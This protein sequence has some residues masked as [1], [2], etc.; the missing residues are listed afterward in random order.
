MAIGLWRFSIRNGI[1]AN[2]DDSSCFNAVMK[3]RRDA[4]VRL[5]PMECPEGL[6]ALS[7]TAD[8]I[9]G[10]CHPLKPVLVVLMVV[11]AAQCLTPMTKSHII[12]FAGDDQ[13]P[14]DGFAKLCSKLDIGVLGASLSWLSHIE[15]HRFA[16]NN[17]GR[18]HFMPVYL[19]R[20]TEAK[21]GRHPQDQHRGNAL[22]RITVLPGM[23][24]SS[25]P[26]W[27]CS[28]H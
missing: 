24:S 15:T 17:I 1:T 25:S 13:A 2:D 3:I 4:H 23:I 5:V 10:R 14:F 26:H 18:G 9:G 11:V 21:T 28:R 19:C 16:V 7:A 6:T 27:L 22:N 8:E 12:D 20:H